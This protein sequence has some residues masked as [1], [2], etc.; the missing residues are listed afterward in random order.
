MSAHTQQLVEQLAEHLS[1]RGEKLATAESCTGGLIAKTLTD[2]AG[3]SVWFDRGFVTYSN[4][5]KTEMLTIPA[6]VIE[7]YGAVSE[8]VAN[9]M[10]SGALRHSAA[11][12]AIA[13]TGIAGPGGG[14][15]EKPVGTVWIG[16]G[17]KR[18][19]VAQKYLFSGD[20][21]M[22]RQATLEMGLVNMKHLLDIG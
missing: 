22:V 2:L 20:R 17:S 13:V 15:E 1:K 3:S 10:V 18:Q 7:E 21:D 16:V 5:A 14:S 12:Y 4:A 11:D 19:V 9:A 6:S 8:A